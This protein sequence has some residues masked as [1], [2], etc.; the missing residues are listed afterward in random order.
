MSEFPG[1]FAIGL[2]AFVLPD[3]HYHLLPPLPGDIAQRPTSDRIVILDG[4]GEGNPDYRVAD[5]AIVVRRFRR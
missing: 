4:N 2:L 3:N 5:K 1:R